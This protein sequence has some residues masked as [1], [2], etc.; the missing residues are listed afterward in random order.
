MLESRTRAWYYKCQFDDELSDRVHQGFDAMKQRQY[1][2]WVYPDKPL[3]HVG[4]GTEHVVLSLNYSIDNVPLALRIPLHGIGRSWEESRTA[5]DIEAFVKAE[6]FEK[7]PEF[8]LPVQGKV[9]D[10]THYAHLVPLYEGKEQG[11]CI[12]VNGAHILIDP[13]SML[14]KPNT[15]F[16][17]YIV[18]QDL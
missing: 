8:V 4:Q 3:T 1:S 16:K 10:K 6:Y 14:M 17:P 9:G 7:V 11:H 18:G 2:R 12:I 5:Q 13:E 15:S